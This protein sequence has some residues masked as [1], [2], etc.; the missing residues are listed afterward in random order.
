MA[1]I[2]FAVVL[3]LLIGHGL[4]SLTRLRNFAWL[5]AW[6]AWLQAR[7]GSGG[8][9]SGGWALLPLVGLPVLAVMAVQT[10]LA[11]GWLLGLFSFVFSVLVLFYCWGPHDLD[12][13][14]EQIIEA[15]DRSQFRQAAAALWPDR[16]EPSLDAP[17]LVEAL[18]RGAL[19]RWFGVLLWFVLLGPAGALLYRL[20]AVLAEDASAESINP[21]VRAASADLL[22]VLDWPAALLMTLGMAMAADFDSV[23]RAWQDWLADGWRLD[24]SFLTVA[25][26]ACV[27]RELA[28]D[29]VDEETGDTDSAAPPAMPELRDAMSL[30][31]RILLL[32]LAVMALL[33]LAGWVG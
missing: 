2:L 27:A 13:D 25:A 31:W 19:R 9:W 17:A 1:A 8:L 14:V 21:D 4:P 33:V 18:F 30:A 16:A 11:D 28:Q 6:G 20:T 23:Y 15:T 22:Q 5:S 26:R 12:V 7:L 29:A 32:W 3:A 10:G 24:A